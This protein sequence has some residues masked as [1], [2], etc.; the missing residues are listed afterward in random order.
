[1][2][3]KNFFERP[4]ADE[5][6]GAGEQ[7]AADKQQGDVI[8]KRQQNEQHERHAKAVDGAHGAV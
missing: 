4:T 6:D 2:V 7:R 1:V 8:R 5:L 3:W